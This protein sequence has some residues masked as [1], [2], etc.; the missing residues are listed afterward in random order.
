[1]VVSWLFDSD[2]DFRRPYDRNLA[3]LLAEPSFNQHVPPPIALKC[4]A[5]RDLGNL[6]V[7][8]NRPIRDTDARKAVQELFHICYWFARTYAKNW[9]HEGLKYDPSLL[10]EAPAVVAARGAKAEQQA[11]E[12]LKKLSDELAVK[13][14]AVAE[15]KARRESLDAELAN[16]RAELAAAVA[17]AKKK[18]ALVPD[19]HDYSE[20]Q[21]RDLFIDLLLRE[22]GWDPA[23][24]DVCEYPVTGMPNNSG[25]GFCDYVLWGDDG[26]PLAV[27]ETKRTKRDAVIG[28]RQA[29]LYATC[30]E[31][32]F[33]RRPIIYYTNAYETW[34]WDDAHYPPRQVQGFHKKDE[35]ELLIQRRQTRKDPLTQ[36]I[37][38]AIVE[39]SYQHA[40]I[41]EVADDLKSS[42][43]QF[44]I[45]MATGAGKTRTVVA[46]CD[47]LQ[48]CNWVKRVLFLADR[49]ALVNQAVDAFKKHLPD[50]SPVN[51]VTEREAEGSRVYVS[52][53]PTMLNLIEEMK[54]GER[55]FG[56]GHFDL[57]VIDEAH[58]SVYQKYRA[59]F[60]YFDSLLL[61]LTATPRDE[62]DRDTYKLFQL[63]KGVPTYHYE[64]S[65]A[66]ADGY[67]VPPQPVSVPLKFPR[68][69]INYDDLSDEEKDEWD[70]VE[71]DED[72]QIPKRVE[73]EAVNKWLMNAD[74]V[75]KML[76]F[77]MEKGLKVAG[78]DRLGKTIIFAKTRDHAHFI[79]ERFDANYPEFKG[80]FAR[81]IEHKEP[82]AQ[83]ILDDFKEPEKQPHIAISIDMLDTGVDVPECV[84][85]VFFK[86]VRSKTKFFQMLGRGTRMSPNL[87]GLGVDKEFFYVF[88]FCQNLEFFN[89]NAKGIEG[90]L[91]QSLAALL[92]LRRLQLHQALGS[93]AAANNDWASVRKE[94]GD[95]LHETV[96]AM[97]VN[98]FLVRPHRRDVESLWD[99]AAW[100][101]LDAGRYADIGHKLAGLPTTLPPEDETAKRFDLL[102][103]KLQLAVVTHDISYERLRDQAKEIASALEEKKDLP[104]VSAQME[105]IL[106]MQTDEWW[107][108]VTLSMLENAR[109]KLR[110]LVRFIDKVR[111]QIVI[112]DFTDT[113]G[114]ARPMPL[115]AIAP[116]VDI[117]Q[118][119]KKM[120]HFLKEHENHIALRRLREN[121]PLTAKD[122]EELERLL[123]ES[124]QLGDRAAFERA[125]GKQPSLGTFI[126]RLVGLDREAAKK[127]FAEYLN[128]AVYSAKQ[129]RF[130]EMVIQY[131]TQNGVM[132]AAL[133]Y[134]TPYTDLDAAGLDGLFTDEQANR[135]VGILA[136]IQN[137]TGE[138]ASA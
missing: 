16:V 100:D 122:L 40:A 129:I 61:G 42:R 33:G 48:R 136:M 76:A 36:K 59:I 112:T 5:I 109:K 45:V 85:L 62:V 132:D 55:R 69:G 22:A 123:Y 21:T 89:Q 88:D 43:R 18:A 58:R 30:L 35:L 78:G 134:E 80:S 90:S 101:S 70:A 74:T 138:R 44:L 87:F 66:V 12:S 79:R 4:R 68:E 113:Q 99:R 117:A 41:R 97:N 118:Y 27:V 92:F 54:A 135:I 107:T 64:L 91:Q 126:R 119:K 23:A 57:V 84:N 105:L 77:L 46:L 110:D 6:A 11:A 2:S 81:V 104:M 47:L 29:E 124:T 63:E 60:E 8:S 38:R 1:M 17:E 28:Q 131:L 73:P 128:T 19:N 14:K 67:L 96:S 50:S 93:P 25:E 116:A 51:L 103:L 37:N 75:D 98:N 130:V 111:R 13:D 26:L 72:G 49:N 94:V 120:R 53:Y 39:R 114:E 102:M 125:Y 24:K 15:E 115:T 86:L 34:V 3:A 108:D 95:V 56:V 65:E 83:S 133:L 32:K 71:W 10:P 7:H 31:K 82:Y 20:A 106:D 137:N 9:S 121:L 52:T 127:A